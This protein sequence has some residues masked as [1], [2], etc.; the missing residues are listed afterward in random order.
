MPSGRSPM[1]LSAAFSW[2]RGPYAA[3]VVSAQGLLPELH[4]AHLHVRELG[5]KGLI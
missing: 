1:W 3:P 2:L 4:C 5:L